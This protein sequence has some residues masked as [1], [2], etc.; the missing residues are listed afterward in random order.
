M[1]KR[2]IEY[3][4]YYQVDNPLINIF[5][6]LFIGLHAGDG[7]EM[8]SR[9]LIKAYPTEKVGNFCMANGKVMVIEYSDLP[10]AQAQRKNPDGSLVFELGSIAIHMISVKFV[11]H[12][13]ADGFALPIHRA[14]KKIPYIDSDG[15][16]ITPTEPNGI[17]LETFVFDAL[18][19]AQKSVILQTLREEE[20]APVKNA[21]GVDSPQVT[22]QMM[23]Q[24]AANWLQA[25]GVD[26]PQKEDGS[27][28]CVI[29]IAPSFALSAEDVIAKKDTVPAIK[30]GDTVSLD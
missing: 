1:K 30:S 6:P 26:V 28:D 7:A 29:E 27:P 2:G 16:Q 25:A 22:R 13:N 5:D 14:D 8:S 21:S 9:A 15:S 18:P 3:I 17:K 4:S 24:R 23:I 20:F 10:D 12:L 19:L 11:E